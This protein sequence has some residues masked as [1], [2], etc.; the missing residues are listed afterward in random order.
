MDLSTTEELRSTFLDAVLRHL[1]AAVIIAAPDGRILLANDQVQKIFRQAFD[2]ATTVDEYRAR[3]RSVHPGG[4]A[5]DEDDLPMSRSLR[6]R[7]IVEH[8]DVVF[9][10]GDGTAGVIRVSSA[11]VEDERGELV[12]AV[13]TFHDVTDERREREALALLADASAIAGESLEYDRT[14]ERIARLS[15]PKFADMA[16]VHLLD[17]SGTLGRQ[18]V[19]AADPNKEAAMREIWTQFPTMT[20]PLLSVIA[21]GR[22]RLSSVFPDAT[23]DA[24]EDPAHAAAMRT[25]GMR[26]VITVPLLG[27]G[28]PYGTMSFVLTNATRAYDGFD[29]LIA[30]E[31]ARRASGAVER[32]RL[33][34][35]ERAQRLLAEQSS[36]RL[37]YLQR[38]TEAL[39][40]AVT[41]D[42]VVHAVTNEMR[43]AL[44]ATVV[45][46]AML[47]DDQEVAEVTGAAGLSDAVAERYRTVRLDSG[48]PITEAIRT[49]T[50]IW[51]GNRAEAAARSP[52]VRNARS[53][54]QSWA[55]IPLEVRGAILGA[56]GL[57][58]AQERAFDDDERSFISGAAA[59][60]SLA[61]ERSFLFDSERHAR[62]E[63]ENASRAKDE[64]LAI[65][66]HELRTPL[67]SVLGWADLLRMT[68]HDDAV[69]V[70]QLTALRN[71]A[72]VQARLI[73]D[74]LD[75]SRIV[76]GKLRIVRR[77][78]ELVDTVRS[79]VQSQRINAEGAGV[80]L[81]FETNTDEA[82][83]DGDPDRMQQVVTNLVANA[84]KFTP[85]GGSARVSVQRRDGEVDIIVS[86]TG[87]GITPEFLPQV[88]DRFRQA[89]VGDS[90]TYSG[91][92]LGLSIVQHIVQL[93]G[94]T[95]RAES[96]G[97]NEG[98]TFTVTLTL[99]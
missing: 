39:A 34:E 65:L 68:R 74:L 35:A 83:F 18:E 48:I 17:D 58:F 2:G 70:E 45:V 30:E 31:I 6:D 97:V 27:S 23:W 87:G 4:T 43:V 56:I 9:S 93:H 92:G 22:G 21:A 24:L 66:S 11:P 49:R 12:A 90:R 79:S 40:K 15:I 25:L 14:L 55:A 3:L 60:C 52:F 41:V 88:F 1:P 86:D 67:T 53:D 42:D 7:E 61:L 16:F 77:R 73:D 78:A 13:V 72:L 85:P 38:L 89:S 44:D 29:L 75:V 5:Y 32:S 98:A 99:V 69:L 63:A 95:V 20:A 81:S 50:A 57:S 82:W 36:R 28:A 96:D 62:E 76:T 33:F 84:I 8:E 46:V 51:I 91:L 10:R 59:Q 47:T 19:A 26:S 71:A 80:A 94:G 37:G 64:F 54:S